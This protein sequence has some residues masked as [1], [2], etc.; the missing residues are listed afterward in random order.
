[1]DQQQIERLHARAKCLSE[2]VELIDKR[3]EED[4]SIEYS[5]ISRQLE[6]IVYGRFEALSSDDIE[7]IY[8]YVDSYLGI[9]TNNKNIPV[10]G[11]VFSRK[12]KKLAIPRAILKP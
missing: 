1:M 12:K 10:N 11:Y 3:A 9:I 5:E 8:D 4:G 2:I 7:G 6:R